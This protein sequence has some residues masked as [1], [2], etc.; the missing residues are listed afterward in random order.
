MRNSAAQQ[1]RPWPEV[2]LEYALA[3]ASGGF[4]IFPVVPNGERAKHPLVADWPNEASSIPDKI[5]AWWMK[6]PGAGI[7]I[8][9]GPA[10]GFSVIDVDIAVD[11]DGVV[12][13]G[14]DTLRALE[15]D[16]RFK[17]PTPFAVIRTPSGGKQF[18]IR[19]GD[20][21]TKGGQNA[22][23]A[24]PAPKVDVRG[25][26]GYV[27]APPSLLDYRKNGRAIK[28]HYTHDGRFPESRAAIDALPIEMGFAEL[29]RERAPALS[30]PANDNAIT[31]VASVLTPVDSPSVAAELPDWTPNP[32][33]AAY[34][35]AVLAGIADDLARVTSGRNAAINQAAFRAARFARQGC[36]SVADIEP[37]LVRASHNNGYCAKHGRTGRSKAQATIQSGIR[38]VQRGGGDRI[39]L[40]A[41][42][43]ATGY[44]PAT[45]PVE[46]F[47]NGVRG[48]SERGTAA[49]EFQCHDEDAPRHVHKYV[50][51]GLIPEV[52]DP[53]LLCGQAKAGKSAIA[54][55]LA[56]CLALGR[57]FFGKKIDRRGGTLFLLSE[58]SATMRDRLAA[59]YRGKLADGEFS[60]AATG[61]MI[62]TRRLPILWRDVARLSHAPTFE[63]AI[64]TC[65]NAKTHME[66]TYGVPL[67]LIVIDVALPAFAFDGDP[68]GAT[69]YAAMT[70]LQRLSRETGVTVLATHHYGKNIQSGPTG[71]FAWG[72]GA[73]A[74]LAVTAET[75]THGAASSREISLP[76]NRYGPAGWMHNFRLEDVPLVTFEDGETWGAPIVREVGGTIIELAAGPRLSPSGRLYVESLRQALET[77]GESFDGGPAERLV[78]RDRVRDL[79]L[80]GHQGSGGTPQQQADARRKAFANGERDAVRKHRA[81][82][83]TVGQ[84][85]LVYLIDGDA[86]LADAVMSNPGIQPEI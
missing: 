38:A 19:T 77:H 21:L 26:G 63:A 40:S 64:Q 13:D 47:C 65:R 24:I 18:Y 84:R 12:A 60:D 83:S 56:T 80:A 27:V 58:G 5:R 28:A 61:D 6:F 8:V 74:I 35:R 45:S 79:F 76:L 11:D 53:M 66:S 31:V 67:R 49:T 23:G 30:V 68:D 36:F 51:R 72:A 34:G 20:I 86:N 42:N 10:N 2:A 29:I 82:A 57:P 46:A 3:Y 62:N 73:S 25:D 44:D 48:D 37:A 78:D 71:S 55:E 54:L 85:T 43:I 9:T 14:N 70:A 59:I 52:D 75:S 17:M 69:V 39:D 1:T 50:V 16:G 4:K 33:M 7:G 41:I 15:S 81:G 32:S 22:I